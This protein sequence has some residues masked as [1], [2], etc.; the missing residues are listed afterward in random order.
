M[1]VA[2][3]IAVV[4]TVLSLS[5]GALDV[6]ALMGFG[7]VSAGSVYWLAPQYPD[8]FETDGESDTDRRQTLVAS[9][10]DLA[11]FCLA[12]AGLAYAWSSLGWV[13]A[14]ALTTVPDTAP[15]TL[16]VALVGVLI[17][18]AVPLFAERQ[19]A[20]HRFRGPLQGET[21]GQVLRMGAGVLVLLVAPGTLLGFLGTFVASRL[22]ILC[23]W[24]IAGQ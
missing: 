17:G 18:G 21:A 11:M 2:V 14:A 7:A 1:K 9:L 4:A 24:Q 10:F 19:I 20:F 15:A 16:L 5:I 3:V 13:E 23:W 6:A 22:T 12:T 8:L